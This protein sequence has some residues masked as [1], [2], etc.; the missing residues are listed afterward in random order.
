[1]VLQ[2][3]ARREGRITTAEVV[4]VAEFGNEVVSLENNV[5]H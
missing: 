2:G 1:M 4:D 5:E 3:E